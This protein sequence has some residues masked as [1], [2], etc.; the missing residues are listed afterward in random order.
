VAE[1]TQ[2]ADYTCG[3]TGG[4]MGNGCNAAGQILVGG[5]GVR[6]PTAP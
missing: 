5:P 1:A 2:D 3:N 6:L 4:W